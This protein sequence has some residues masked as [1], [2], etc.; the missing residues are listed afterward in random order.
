MRLF[1]LVGKSLSH[2]FSKDY[3]TRKFT[4]EN[5]TDCIYE[6][7]EL[8]RVEQVPALIATHSNLQGLNVT[9]PYKEAVIQFIDFI[10]ETAEEIGACNCVK[11]INERLYGFNTDVIGFKMSLQKKLQPHHTKAL[12][13]GTGGSSKAVQCALGQ[14]SISHC[15][16][17][18][19]P[20]LQQIGYQEVGDQILDE[21]NI[22]IN[23]TPLGMYPNVDDDPPIPYDY[24]TPKHLVYDLIYNPSLT[25][26]LNQ[27][28]K[29]GAQ[30]SN[31]YEM[32]VL[33]AEESWRIWNS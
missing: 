4:E 30:I 21:Y 23:T 13:L 26:F 29:R 16:V 7:F 25:K 18:R 10:D 2:S 24:L 31:G 33:Q 8:Q 22:I 5:I 15:V 28:Q 20:K 1:G 9:I 19:H 12:V 6:N 14:L 17:S 32:L 27:A 3:F 11:I